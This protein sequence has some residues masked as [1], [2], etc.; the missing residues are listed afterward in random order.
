MDKEYRLTKDE[1]GEIAKAGLVAAWT[2][3]QNLHD[4]DLSLKVGAHVCIKAFRAAS[5][6]FHEKR[7]EIGF[8]HPE[9]KYVSWPNI[10]VKDVVCA[11]MGGISMPN[12]EEISPQSVAGFQIMAFAKAV[13]FLS[14]INHA[15]LELMDDEPFMADSDVEGLMDFEK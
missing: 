14:A 10:D 11:A 13:S 7:R 1:E 3:L 2:T 12:C 8:R 5:T 6:A 4:D 9:F 15:S